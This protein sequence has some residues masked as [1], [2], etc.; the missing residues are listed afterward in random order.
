MASLIPMRGL[1][2][3]PDAEV[4]LAPLV[5]DSL[6]Q[7]SCKKPL[8]IRDYRSWLAIALCLSDILPSVWLAGGLCTKNQRK[9]FYFHWLP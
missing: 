2:R 1:L 9:L 8:K 5:G 3:A 4:M 6:R 7:E